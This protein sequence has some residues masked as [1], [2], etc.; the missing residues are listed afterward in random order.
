MRQ[1]KI[2]ETVD[3]LREIEY[4]E[5]PTKLKLIFKYK[6]DTADD[7]QEDSRILKE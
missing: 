1:E 7:Y 5:N 6:V 2:T 3:L 4:C